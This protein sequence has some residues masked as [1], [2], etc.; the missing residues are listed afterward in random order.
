LELYTVDKLKTITPPGLAH[1]KNRFEDPSEPAKSWSWETF[2]D[3]YKCLGFHFMIARVAQRGTMFRD[4]KLPALCTML[5][6]R[7]STKVEFT[8][9]APHHDWMLCTVNSI[10]GAAKEILSTALIQMHDRNVAYI[11]HHF[12]PLALV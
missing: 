1:W 5:A 8:T 10:K 3:V 9:M 6:S 4:L 11:V 2:S 7:W 12:G